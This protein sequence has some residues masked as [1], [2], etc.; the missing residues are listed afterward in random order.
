MPSGPTLVV[1]Y[2]Q[3]ARDCELWRAAMEVS[4]DIHLALPGEHLPDWARESGLAQRV[5]MLPMWSLGSESSRWFPGLRG[6]VNQLTPGLVHVDGEAW[7]FPVQAL[8]RSGQSVVAHGAENVITDAP[9]PY[10]VRRTG[11]TSVLNRLSGYIAWGQTGLE[12]IRAAGLPVTTPT[13]MI[14][15]RPPAAQFFLAQPPRTEDGPVRIAAIGRFVRAKGFDL[16]ITAAVAAAAEGPIEVH[17]MGAGPELT[18]LQKLAEAAPIPVVLHPPGGPARVSELIA[19]CDAVVVASRR[20][21]TWMEQWCRVAAEALLAGR[22]VFAAATGD[23]P[24]T[25]GVE[26]WLFAED[27]EVALASL[28]NSQRSLPARRVAADLALQQAARFHVPTYAIDLL[29]LW[30]EVRSSKTVRK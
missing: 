21:R 11:L 8:V 9:W 12:A 26:D 15:T 17:L 10:R 29:G 5:T 18:A 28:I 4:N 7:S 2:S 6:L 25:V 14:P 3:A 22:P 16:V 13:R 1:A 23:L 27:D 24:N 19:S 30:D 20:T